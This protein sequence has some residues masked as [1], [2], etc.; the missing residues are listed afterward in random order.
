MVKPLLDRAQVH[1]LLD[2][3]EVVRQPQLDGVNR[4]VEG[5][6]VLVLPH[7]LDQRVLQELSLVRDPARTVR[8]W[9]ER[10]LDDSVDRFL[11]R[12]VSGENSIPRLKTKKINWYGL[13]RSDKHFQNEQ[14]EKDS[15]ATVPT[16][17]I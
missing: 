8:R 13:F 14:V 4:Q 12:L 5:P 7:A 2:D 10:R 3:C 11:V 1:R 6:S 9:N 16:R 15:P 17:A